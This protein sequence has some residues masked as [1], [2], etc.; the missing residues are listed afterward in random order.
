MKMYSFIRFCSLIG[1]RVSK[2]GCDWLRKLSCDQV[3]WMWLVGYTWWGRNRVPDVLAA[4][5][6][7]DSLWPSSC[8]LI[9]SSHHPPRHLPRSTGSTTSFPLPSILPLSSFT[10]FSYLHHPVFSY[11]LPLS[12]PCLVLITTLFS[13]FSCYSSSYTCC[14]WFFLLTLIFLSLPTFLTCS[15]LIIFLSSSSFYC[16]V[17]VQ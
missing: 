11:F 4:A 9:G 16:P 14:S 12:P 8:R 2:L 1:S 3:G 7:G 10:F 15:C 13:S 5:A 6:R 17:M